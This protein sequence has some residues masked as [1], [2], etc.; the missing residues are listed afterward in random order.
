LILSSVGSFRI[1]A[2][3]TQVCEVCLAADHEKGCK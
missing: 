2:V 3:P 1:I